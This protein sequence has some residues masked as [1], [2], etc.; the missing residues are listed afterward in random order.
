MTENDILI[1][2]GHI[3][4]GTG[5][6]SFQGSILVTGGI[7]SEILKEEIEH[8]ADTIIDASGLSI[9]PGFIDVHNHGDLSILYYPRADG[10]VRQG[11]TTFVGGQCGNS[12]GPFGEWIGLPW[13]LRDLY[14]DISPK[15]YGTDWLKPREQVNKRHRELYGWEIDWNTLGEFFERVEDKGLSPNFVPLVG[16]G[17]VRSLVMG[18][19]FE[20]SATDEEVNEMLVHIEQAM[21]E[22]CVGI[23]V[24]RDYDPGIWADFNEVL[25]CAK[26]AA[27]FDGIY[28]SHSLRTG[29]RKPRRPGVFP[30]IKTEGVLE[31]IR[32]GREAKMPIQISHLNIV[33]DVRPDSRQ[34]TEAAVKETLR[35]IDEANEE[36]IDVSFDTIPH[37]LTGGI[38][39]SPW[40]AS[41]LE[42]W[43]RITGSLEQFAR[44]LRM[45][46]FREEI[47]TNIWNGKNYYFNP[48]ITP[49][50]ASSRT[51]VECSE[52]SFV[53][54]TVKDIS[55]ELEAEELDA[56][57][58]VLI[59]DPYTKAIRTGDDDWVKLEFYK[60]PQM[61]IGVDTFAVDET[62]EGR[63]MPVSYPNQN[64]FNGFPRFLRRAVRETQTLTLEEAVMQITSFPAKKFKLKNRG[65]LKQ[66]A[67]ADIVV[68]NADN[69]KDVGTQIEPRLYPKGIE[70]VIINGVQVVKNS[71]HT[72]ALPGKILYRE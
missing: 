4:D 11:I 65:V 52:Q 3:V 49:N 56:L 48:N 21:E 39:T 67:Y 68:M 6:K 57:L 50:W 43:V 17:D 36:G 13:L 71:E 70:H 53:N 5:S 59:V 9:T 44:A 26:V 35:I 16:H 33:Y 10:F 19:D 60:H 1:K 12:P 34:M 42:P 32:I 64:S 31:A 18:P 46:D 37:H 15:M 69:V 30:P 22:G 62:R 72:G 20:R 24:G 38:S 40:L 66:G 55:Q 58:D 61:M 45:P 28:A 41:S 47:K 23:S 7:I 54:K 63:H 27:S 29:H 14:L 25:A 8:D 2:D 51:I